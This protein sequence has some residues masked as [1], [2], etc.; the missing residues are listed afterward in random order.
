[1]YRIVNFVLLSQKIDFLI[2]CFL[3]VSASKGK[4]MGCWS[5]VTLVSAFPVW[6]VVTLVNKRLPCVCLPQFSRS[7]P[8]KLW[9]DI[10]TRHK[11]QEKIEGQGVEGPRVQ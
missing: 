6:S 4:N 7:G 8:K 1:M 3:Q 5:V 9:V 10:H 11:Y 2:F